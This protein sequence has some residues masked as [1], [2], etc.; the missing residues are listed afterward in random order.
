M[1]ASWPHAIY[2]GLVIKSACGTL[3]RKTTSNEALLVSV[4][5]YPE[6]LEI[7]HIQ[8]LRTYVL[9]QPVGLD[10]L[11]RYEDKHSEESSPALGQMLACV[12]L[13]EGVRDWADGDLR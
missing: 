3:G 6:L 4:G 2:Q 1:E 8:C 12:E 11:V 13:P 5:S 10:K 9:M 7:N